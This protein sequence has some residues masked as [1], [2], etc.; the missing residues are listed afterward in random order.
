MS[1][2]AIGIRAPL[3]SERQPHGNHR[4]ESK[5]GT[6]SGAKSYPIYVAGEWQTS[7][8]PLAVRNPY[9]GDVIGVTYQASRDQLEQAIVAAERAPSRSRASRRPTSGS[10][11]SRR[12]PP[13]SKSVA[14][15][16]RA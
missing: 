1:Y 3:A 7:Q 8:E 11:C 15:K 2:H 4:S 6:T 12:W 14:T 13:A 9:S 5:S 10:R 16:S